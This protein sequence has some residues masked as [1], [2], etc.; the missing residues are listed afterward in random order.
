MVHGKK[1]R[2]RILVCVHTADLLRQCFGPPSDM[3]VAEIC[4][5]HRVAVYPRRVQKAL[6]YLGARVSSQHDRTIE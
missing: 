5:R 1:A 6:P 2:E 3:R 4:R